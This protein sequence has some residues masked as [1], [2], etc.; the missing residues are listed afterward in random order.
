MSNSHTMQVLRAL[1]APETPKFFGARLAHVRKERGLTQ[2][3]L[4]DL[5]GCHWITI[6]RVERGKFEVT[7]ERAVRL[8]DALDVDI[9]YLLVWPGG[10]WKTVLGSNVEHSVAY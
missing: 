7:A 1:I 6:S 4:A 2:Q 3:G 8:C 10:E 5:A 9:F